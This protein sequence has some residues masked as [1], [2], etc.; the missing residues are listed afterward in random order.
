MI[1]NVFDLTGRETF[2][3]VKTDNIGNPG[4]EE[5]IVEHAESLNTVLI[6]PREN[7]RNYEW[8]LQRQ[9]HPIIEDFYGNDGTIDFQFNNTF[10][11]SDF[12][13]NL[14]DRKNDEIK[15]LQIFFE[16]QT[17]ILKE[18]QIFN[19]DSDPGKSRNILLVPDW[20]NAEM[21]EVILRNCGM[22]RRNK[23][24]LLLWRSAAICL[25]AYH[26]LVQRNIEEND[27][28]IVIDVEN[29]GVFHISVLSMK[30][31]GD[32]L[33]PVR[34][35]FSPDDKKDKNGFSYTTGGECH[36]C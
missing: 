16:L 25:G 36:P 20:Y 33:V 30:R 12:L 6:Q 28:V 24:T 5:N 4:E 34:R 19:E 35:Y 7:S 14:L 10:I 2:Y 23:K 21:Q 29:R 17:D 13:N 1:A 3:R 18:K 32:W 8:Y 11:L 22:P 15:H 27:H 26:E 31:D 9:D